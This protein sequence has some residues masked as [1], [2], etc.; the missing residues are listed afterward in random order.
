MKIDITIIQSGYIW[1]FFFLSIVTLL[2]GVL[3]YFVEKDRKQKK[4]K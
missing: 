1:S 3:V 2:I 4:K